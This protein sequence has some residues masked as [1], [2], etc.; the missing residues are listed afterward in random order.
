VSNQDQRDNN[1]NGIGDDC[2]PSVQGG[3][4]CALVSVSSRT[5]GGPLQLLL[6]VLLGLG[7]VAGF[8]RLSVGSRRR[9]LLS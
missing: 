8:R 3:P 7:L 9:A 4:H 2:E 6:S 1:M 5:S